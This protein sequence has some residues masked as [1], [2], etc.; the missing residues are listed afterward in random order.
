[1]KKRILIAAGGTGGHLYP[2]MSVASQL[3]NV[4]ILFAASGL[5]DNPFFGGGYPFKSIDAAPLS[6]SPWHW[7]VNG[8]RLLRGCW[9]SRRL[10]A[11]Y[12]PH[13]VVGFGSYHTFPVLL[14]ASQGRYPI[15][16]HEQNSKPGKVIS[17]FAKKALLTATFFPSAAA[18]LPGKA[19]SLAMPLREN[20]SPAAVSRQLAAEYFNLDPSKVTLLVFGGSQGAQFLN[21]LM[22]DLFSSRLLWPQGLQLLHFTGSAASV[23]EL[24][25]CYGRAQISAVVK[26]F[27]PAMQMAWKLADLVIGRSGAGTIA[28]QLAFGVPAIFIPYPHLADNHQESNADFVVDQVG[29]GWKMQQ[30]G[31]TAQKLLPLLLPLLLPESPALHAKWQNLRAYSRCQEEL[32]HFAP[33]VEELLG[34]FNDAY[35][36]DTQRS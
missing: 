25:E 29:G 27:E 18:A 22:L 14:A 3:R 11:E 35:P 26:A 21:S 8:S 5:G 13:L 33:L 23:A 1:M 6:G 28:E 19:V 7:L 15:V 34:R 30:A 2:A 32:P 20:F 24:E 36:V 12:R 10:L 17:F 16:L 31:A 9:Q 4:D